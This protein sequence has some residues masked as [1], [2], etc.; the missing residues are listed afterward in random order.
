MTLPVQKPKVL[1]SSKVMRNAFVWIQLI[2][3]LLFADQLYLI[4]LG[5]KVNSRDQINL[6][7]R[8][9]VKASHI[10]EASQLTTA[11]CEVD[12]LKYFE[13]LMVDHEKLI[14]GI[15]DIARIKDQFFSDYWGEIKSLGAWGGDFILAS[16]T[17]TPEETKSYFNQKGFEVLFSYDQLALS[18]S[19]V[20]ERV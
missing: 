18:P 15:L 10:E 3:I 5:N 1:F 2:L 6:Y 4:Y 19:Q 16:S 8:K 17:H 9:K 7:R 13:E 11:F 20:E 14:S 12:N